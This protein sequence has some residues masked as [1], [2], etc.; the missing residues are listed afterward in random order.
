NVCLKH[1]KAES[2]RPQ[3]KDHL[4]NS[5]DVAETPNKSCTF[6]NSCGTKASRKKMKVI[7]MIHAFDSQVI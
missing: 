5:N 2:P 7:I 3:S 6:Q 4:N 1:E